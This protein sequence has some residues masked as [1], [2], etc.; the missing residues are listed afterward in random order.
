M[1][2]SILGGLA[3]KFLDEAFSDDKDQRNE[4]WYQQDKNTELQREFAQ[5]GIR[6]K[7]ADAQAAGLSPLFAVAGSGALYSPNP[8]TIGGG[9]DDQFGTRMGQSITRAIQGQSTAAEKALHVAQ[10]RVLESQADKNQAEAFYYASSASRSVQTS[11]QS[12]SFPPVV[13]PGSGIAG[14]V[15]PKAPDAIAPRVND[16]SLS[17]TQNP[18]WERHQLGDGVVIDL[19]RSDEGPAEAA[20]NPTLWPSILMRNVQEHG[21]RWPSDV[22]TSPAATDRRS[23]AIGDLIDWVRGKARIPFDALREYNS[24]R[25]DYPAGRSY[26]P[27]PG[28]ESHMRRFRRK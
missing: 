21:A 22:V 4:A 1:I 15:T 18:F 7:V 11:G 10:L 12:G 13:G 6:W 20:E 17:A 28:W 23:S 8:I 9:S 27:G 26:S 19:P 25:H 16:Q 5:N 24:G 14:L 3:G 2:E